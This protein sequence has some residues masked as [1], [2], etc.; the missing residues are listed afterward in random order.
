MLSEEHELAVLSAHLLHGALANQL[1]RAN[2]AAD[3]CAAQPG[4]ALLHGGR[5]KGAS[6]TAG[7]GASSRALA[8]RLQALQ[9]QVEE[10]VG[11]EQRG[12]AQQNHHQSLEHRHHRT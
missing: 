9:V 3:V 11:E 2:L 7:G 5:F 8:G 4:A 6:V 10:Q 12:Q 1:E